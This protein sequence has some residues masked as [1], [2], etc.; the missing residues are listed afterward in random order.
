MQKA[1]VK[2]YVWK[3]VREEGGDDGRKKGM[4]EERK[5]GGKE[6]RSIES[7]VGRNGRTLFADLCETIMIFKI[8]LC[9]NQ[10]FKYSICVCHFC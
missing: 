9:T 8:Q 7:S 10:A 3:E 2:M 6:G 4:E 5:K 1:E